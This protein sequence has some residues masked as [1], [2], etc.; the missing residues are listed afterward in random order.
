M[1]GRRIDAW[2][3]LKETY[4][5]W[6][7]DNALRFGAALSYYTVFSLPPLLFLVVAVAGVIYG[8]EAAQGHLVA[9]A[10]GVVGELGAEAIQ[11]ILQHTGGGTRS[12]LAAIT[13]FVVLV[14]GAT[15]V[16]AE[17][18]HS[19]NVIWGIRE[20]PGR[21]IVSMLRTRILSFAVVLGIGFFML[22][23]LVLSALVSALGGVLR[24][25]WFIPLHVVYVLHVLN[26]LVSF[27]VVTVLFA[28][29]YK[30]LP[31]GR[32]AWRDVW[33]GAAAT[34][35]LFTIGK[36]FVGLYLGGSGIVSAYRATGSLIV[37]FVWIYFSAQILYLGAE[38]TEV[39]A[40][41]RGRTIEPSW[42]AEWIPEGAPEG[43]EGPTDRK[44]TAA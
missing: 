7:R 5:E 39:Y 43:G 6:R 35:L 4:A 42:H 17:L 13:G 29:I 12:I 41:R 10:K 20:K 24:D 14:V 32:I 16:F 9:Q 40:R 36:F 19:L 27:A 22:V 33:L 30:V 1:K 25:L 34:A 21:S 38:F 28:M 44:D 31:Y 15:A 11:S 23:S 18:Q 2:S 8:E 3:L 26:F 37:L